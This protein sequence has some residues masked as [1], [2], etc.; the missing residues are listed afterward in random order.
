[1][2]VDETVIP[3]ILLAWSEKIVNFYIIIILF[4][5]SNGSHFNEII[6]LFLMETA[7]YILR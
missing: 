1:M 7:K 5:P 4:S 6:N 3:K 2:V